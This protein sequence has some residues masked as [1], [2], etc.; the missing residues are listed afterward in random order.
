[1]SSFF[2]TFQQ[3]YRKELKSDPIFVDLDIGEIDTVV[4][5]SAQLVE[6]FKHLRKSL[7]SHG[8]FRY[9]YLK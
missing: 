8:L 6:C 3:F 9:F 1:M 5:Q 2:L 7:F 4:D